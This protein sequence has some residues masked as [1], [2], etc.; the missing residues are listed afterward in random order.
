[1]FFFRCKLL[2]HIMFLLFIFLI[3][4]DLSI[5]FIIIFIRDFIH[6]EEIFSIIVVVMLWRCVKVLSTILVNT[7]EFISL[8]FYQLRE[9]TIINYCLFLLFMLYNFL[10]SFSNLDDLLG[11]TKLWIVDHSLETIKVVTLHQH[12]F[13]VLDHGNAWIIQMD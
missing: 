10:N 11:I 7:C 5:L 6:L 8:S 1:L 9:V 4:L 12:R 3:Y 2:T 13:L